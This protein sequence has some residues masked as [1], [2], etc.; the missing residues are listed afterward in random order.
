MIRCCRTVVVTDCLFETA[1]AC[2]PQYWSRW[3]YQLKLGKS[4]EV[5]SRSSRWRQCSFLVSGHNAINLTER[6]PSIGSDLMG[7]FMAGMTSTDIESRAAGATTVPLVS[8]KPALPILSPGMVMCLG[9]NYVDH[10]KEGG[11]DIPEYPVFL[12]G[13]INR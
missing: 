6:D 3:N 10:I 7:I 5:F 8:I 13:A 11:Y 2:P 9:L 12:C 4:N 1:A